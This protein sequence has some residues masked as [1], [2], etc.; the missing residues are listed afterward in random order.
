[1]HELTHVLRQTRIVIKPLLPHILDDGR[2]AERSLMLAPYRR[3]ISCHAS[4]DCEKKLSTP[5]DG[6]PADP[7]KR[8]ICVVYPLESAIWGKNRGPVVGRAVS[9]TGG[10]AVT[11]KSP[12]SL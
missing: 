11:R 7:L 4:P 8:I 1:M 5:A 6:V 2:W 9:S 12:R 10:V 3:S